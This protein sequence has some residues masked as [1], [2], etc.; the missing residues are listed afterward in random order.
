MRVVS[1]TGECDRFSGMDFSSY[2]EC[3]QVGNGT[4]GGEM[5][6]MIFEPKHRCQLVD[7]LKFHFCG[8]RSAIESMIIRID[9]LGEEIC[10]GS[11]WVRRL[12]HLPRIRRVIKGIVVVEAIDQRSEDILHFLRRNVQRRVP[13]ELC[14]PGLPA[15]KPLEAGRNKGQQVGRTVPVR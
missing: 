11:N 10:Y 1:F 8:C 6:Q 2:P 3:F 14:P 5:T 4:A 13:F 12:E 9:L 15:I 7:D